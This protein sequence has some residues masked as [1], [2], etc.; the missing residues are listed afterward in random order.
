LVRGEQNRFLGMGGHHSA[1]MDKDEWLTPPYILAALGSFDL[2][3][4]APVARP[5]PMAREHYTVRDNGL[6]KPWSG[7]VW[8][9]PPYGAP[10]VLGPWLR[11]MVDHG[12]GTALIFARTETELFFETVW[13]RA[14]AAL[15]L[16]GRLFFH[17]VD[18]RAAA[19]NAGA[20]SVLVAYGAEDGCIL[21][22]CGIAGQFIYLAAAR[23][24]M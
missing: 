3:P 20:P 5:W 17:H 11:R 4:C 16:R 15:F 8:L 21:R 2:D 7:R 12:F 9:N 23:R 19:A 14:E 22:D 24:E 18:G 10:A 13:A 1:A 6:L